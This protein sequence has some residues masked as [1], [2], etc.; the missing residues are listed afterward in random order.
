MGRNDKKPKVA[1][2]NKNPKSKDIN[3][4]LKGESYDSL[5]GK[6]AFLEVTSTHCCISQ[7]HGIELKNLI[8]C[9]K[10]IES[11]KWVDIYTD[12]GL[13][14]ERNKCISVPLPKSVPTDVKLYSMR[15]SQKMRIYGYR[16]QQY[17]YIIWFD[18][19][20]I[21]CPENKKKSYPA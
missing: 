8:E 12:S 10:K 9:F 11:L 6:I 21:I 4:Q 20:H 5:Y 16:A 14:Y 7:W 2:L 1:N 3:T 18:K 13:N 15:V 17:F 19:N